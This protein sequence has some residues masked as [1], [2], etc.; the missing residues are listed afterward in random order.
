MFV[1]QI[2]YINSDLTFGYEKAPDA[3]NIGGYGYSL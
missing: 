3:W 1:L 2:R